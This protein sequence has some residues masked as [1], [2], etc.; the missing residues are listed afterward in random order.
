M[1]STMHCWKNVVSALLCAALAACAAGG[2]AAQLRIRS[3][4][5]VQGVLTARL[6][7]QPSAAVLDALDNGIVLDFRVDVR[8]YGPAHLGWRSTLAHAAR[9]IELRYFPLSRRY[10]LR[11]LDRGETRSYGARAQLLAA[12]EDLRLELPESW[13]PGAA[14]AYALSIDL[15]RDLLPGSLRLPALLR[16]DWRLSSGD[17]SW[18]SG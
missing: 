4:S 14:R 18:Q 12:L 7:W 15:D 11:D 6:Q 17:F 1:A 16:P 9:H 10:Q 2:D 8:A 13:Q 3:A 5:V